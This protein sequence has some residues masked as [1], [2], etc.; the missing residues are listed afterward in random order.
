MVAAIAA[1][2]GS[3]TTTSP[4]TEAPTPRPSAT[5]APALLAA[6]PTC[7][8]AN[9][10]F[11]RRAERVL[12]TGCLSQG[13][14]ADDP[15]IVWAWDGEAWTAVD[16]SG[17]PA[18]DL[19]GAAYDVRRQVL[20]L[21]GGLSPAASGCSRDTWEWDGTDWNRATASSPAPCNHFKMVYDDTL[22]QVLL[23]GGQDESGQL[24]SGTW[25]WDGATWALMTEDGP[26]SRAHF[27]LVNDN[28]HPQVLL[29]G[30]YDGAVHDEFWS[31]NG[32]EWTRLNIPGPGPRSHLGL[33]FDERSGT[34]IAFGGASTAST[35]SSL[36]NE[37]WI[38]DGGRWSL[39]GEPGPSARGSPGMTFDPALGRVVLYGGFTADGGVLGD[40]WEWDG[41]A[42]S[43]RAGCPDQDAGK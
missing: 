9:L 24:S 19:G 8:A 22:G 41:Q 28:R 32:I 42:W 20:V 34:L 40:T 21:Y 15:E 1:L 18:R 6:P 7:S 27:G 14:A 36:T 35:M 31:W 29:Y 30:G 33:A 13:V 25:A 37:T 3:C 39:A 17:P 5:A 10:V 4:P 38:L 26:E 11:D 12:M 43:C 16:A 23:F 2:A